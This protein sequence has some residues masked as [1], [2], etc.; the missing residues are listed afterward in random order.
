MLNKESIENIMQTIILLPTWKTVNLYKI[1][2]KVSLH[3]SKDS[4]LPV[5]L[6]NNFPQCHITYLN[7][8]KT[9]RGIHSNPYV[10]QLSSL[11]QI[12]YRASKRTRKAELHRYCA[13]NILTRSQHL[14]HSVYHSASSSHYHIIINPLN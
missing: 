7:S 13:S 11:I 10:T 12:L 5:L 3:W 1:N 6:S 8:S 14:S 2:F 9:K 4:K